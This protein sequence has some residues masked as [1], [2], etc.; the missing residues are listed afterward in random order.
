MLKNATSI[1]ITLIV[2]SSN[3]L[4]FVQF[5]DCD[6][7]CCQP[8]I[9]CCQMTKMVSC[10]SAMTACEKPLLVPLVLVPVN[11]VEQQVDI[12]IIAI[13]EVPTARIS[14]Q[15]FYQSKFDQTI[16]P[17]PPPSFLIPLLI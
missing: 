2:L 10:E 1:I 5:D 9:S 17:E 13:H 12:T 3:V 7:P 16:A 4:P 8:Q 15:Y 11:K 14:E 6:K